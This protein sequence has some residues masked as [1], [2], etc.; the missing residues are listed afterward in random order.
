M[1]GVEAARDLKGRILLVGFGRFGVGSIHRSSVA[2]PEYIRM[3]GAPETPEA[4]LGHQALLMGTET[5]E[6]F[7]GDKVIAATPPGRFRTNSGTALAAAAVA[8]L[9]IACA[10]DILVEEHLAS[11]ALLSVMKRYP[12]TPVAACLF[13][14]AGTAPAQNIQMLGD[15]HSKYLERLPPPARAP[16]A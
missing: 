8:G 2:S 5:W 13:R 15:L 10:P 11:G 4:L 1:E 14:P 7:D 12:P 16:L 9:G 6:F 3:H